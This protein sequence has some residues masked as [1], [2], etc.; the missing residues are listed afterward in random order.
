MIIIRLQ[1]GLGNQMFQYALGRHLSLKNNCQLKLDL[2]LLLDHSSKSDKAV[3]RNFELDVFD[4]DLQ[5]AEKEEVISIVGS[6]SKS[7]LGKVKNL[8]L[9]K[10]GLRKYK[11]EKDR[12]FAPSI[13]KTPSGHCLSG[14]WQ[15]PR[16]FEEIESTIRKDFQFTK[17]VSDSTEYKNYQAAISKGINIGVHVR[18]GD[19]ISNKYYNDLLGVQPLAYYY[20]SLKMIKQKVSEISNVFVFSDDI[21]WCME[22]FMFDE[23]AIFVKN[24]RSK[25]GAARDLSLLAQCQHHV[26]SNST[27]SWWGAWLSQTEKKVVVAPKNWVSPKYLNNKTINAK[28]I[29]PNNWIRL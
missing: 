21:D 14:G 12:S 24:D 2:S 20:N 9:N 15:S 10:L 17:D 18:R 4:L 5:F 8:T 16:Y 13:L 27:F 25:V 11:I 19:Y 1:G 7:V 26:I 23:K 28:D 3:H 22:N 6:R 29:I